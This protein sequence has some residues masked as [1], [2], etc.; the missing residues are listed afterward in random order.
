MIEEVLPHL[1]R[2]E[3]PLPRNPLKYVNAYVVRGRARDLIVDTGLNREECLK[4]MEEGLGELGVDLEKTDF[5]VTHMHADHFGLVSRLVTA[6]SKVY[7]NRPDAEIMRDQSFWESGIIYAGMNGFPEHQLRAALH[8]HPGFKYGSR[9]IPKMSFVK[10]GDQLTV[11]NCHFRCVETPGHTKGHICLYEPEKKIL[12]AGDH[13]LG[14]ITPNIQ[15][16]S[17]QGNPLK[18]YLGSLDK[19]STLQVELV[20][21]GHRRLFRNPRVRIEELKDHH[22]NRADEILLILSKGPKTAFEVASEMT[23]DI[24][25]ESWDQYPVTQK[26]FATG[27]AIAHLRYLHEKDMVTKEEKGKTMAYRR[28]QG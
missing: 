5:F 21:P 3:I 19:V 7:F 11:G 24:H 18:D 12:V 27:E 8:S 6:T 26:W 22:Q 9:S 15:C 17:D 25:Y 16:W 28:N 13:I 23:W 1:Y 2:I 10:E 14:D 4:A 20:L